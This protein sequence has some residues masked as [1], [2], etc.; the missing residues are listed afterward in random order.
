M[1][2]NSDYAVI[3]IS[4]DDGATWA[5]LV[6]GGGGVGDVRVSGALYD[7][8]GRS[9]SNVTGIGEGGVYTAPQQYSAY[10]AG[11]HTH[12]RAHTK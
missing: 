6:R 4:L 5:E 9:G 3:E 10:P 2:A 7:L 12:V 11:G 8:R 1:V